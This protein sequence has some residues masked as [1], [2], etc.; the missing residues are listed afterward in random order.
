MKRMR[1]LLMMYSESLLIEHGLHPVGSVVPI[2]PGA[3]LA[4]SSVDDIPCPVG[5]DLMPVDVVSGCGLAGFVLQAEI[6]VA[7]AYGAGA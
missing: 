2:N 5:D 1:K 7:L 4:D 3:V 6:A